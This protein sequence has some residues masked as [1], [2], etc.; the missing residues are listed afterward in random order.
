MCINHY[1]IQKMKRYILTSILAAIV[2]FAANMAVGFI[3]IYLIPSLE[4]E[5]GNTLIFRPWEDPFM[6]LYFLHPFYIA[7]VLAWIWGRTKSHFNGKIS[8]QAFIFTNIY[9]LVATIPGL[10]LSISS[11]KISVAITLSWA[12]G[13]YIQTYFM[14]LIFAKNL[15]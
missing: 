10:M 2:G 12:V 9:V 15:R 8:K 1:K 7:F 6:S 14:S 3:F 4:G 11:F 5:Y 13:A